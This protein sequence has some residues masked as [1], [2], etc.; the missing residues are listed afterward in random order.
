MD[1][2]QASRACSTESTPAADG[3]SKTPI[4][5]ANVDPTRMVGKPLTDQTRMES[6]EIDTDS[7]C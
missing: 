3:A 5:K 1:S 7:P 6:G 4:A 2:R